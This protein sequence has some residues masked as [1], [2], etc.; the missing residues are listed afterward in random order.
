MPANGAATNFKLELADME[1]R[2]RLT[3]DTCEEGKL[4][5]GE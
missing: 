2:H 1:D 5:L 3:F 4:A